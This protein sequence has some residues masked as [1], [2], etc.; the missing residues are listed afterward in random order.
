MSKSTLLLAWNKRWKKCM[1]FRNI[2]QG[3]R[4]KECARLDEMRLQAV[5]DAEK[6]AVAEKKQQHIDEVMADRCLNVRGNYFSELDA[7]SPSGD[8]YG[9]LLKLTVDGMDQAKFKCPRNLAIIF[10]KCIVV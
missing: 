2:G 5:D 6:A 3:K 10:S 9:Q 7:K 4:C 8:G 1:P